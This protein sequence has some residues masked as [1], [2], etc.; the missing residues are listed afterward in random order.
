MQASGPPY[1]G[2]RYGHVRAHTR[3]TNGSILALI[4]YDKWFH[5]SDFPQ[6]N[7]VFPKAISSLCLE[8]A[9]TQ[10]TRSVS[11]DSSPAKIR[12]S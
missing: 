8:T 6:P 2:S 11:K 10:T 5:L 1:Q 9:E 12:N 4:L 3:K 7:G